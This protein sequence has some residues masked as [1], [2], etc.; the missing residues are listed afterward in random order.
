MFFTDSPEFDYPSAKKAD[1]AKFGKFYH[2]LLDQ[3][4]YLPP[5]QFESAFVSLAHG[6]AEI[7]HTLAAV[8]KALRAVSRGLPR[9]RCEQRTSRTPRRQARSSH[10]GK[11]I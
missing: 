9:E 11:D 10:P 1:T 7:D 8:K 5:S 3:G 2:S 4:V 6:D